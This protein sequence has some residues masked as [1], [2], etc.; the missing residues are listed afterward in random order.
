M[1]E[2][3][4]RRNGS[5]S[6]LQSD[7]RHKFL[8]PLIFYVGTDTT[9]RHLRT[10]GSRAYCNSLDVSENASDF[11]GWHGH[12]ARWHGHLARRIDASREQRRK[13]GE[14][15]NPPN[16]DERNRPQSNPFPGLM[17]LWR[18]LFCYR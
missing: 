18:V 1:G 5:R 2:R 8:T 12:L 14:N 16:V 3:A 11:D 17:F 6:N 15:V 4:H 9:L 10:L 13:L 7:P